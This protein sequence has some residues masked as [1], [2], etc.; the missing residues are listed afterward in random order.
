MKKLSGP[1]F[2]LLMA[3][4]IAMIVG[5]GF[6]PNFAARII[7]PEYRPPLILYLHAG[8]CAAWV[9]LLCVQSA[10][11]R[12]V[13]LRVHMQLG[14]LGFVLGVVLPILGIA[15]EIAMNRWH[16]SLGH[17]TSPVFVSISINDML[18]FATAFGFAMWWRRKP[19]FHKRL[20]LVATC[21]LTTAAFA[22]WPSYIVPTWWFYIFVDTLIVIGII[23]DLLVVRSVHPVYSIGLPALIVGQVLA[24][25]LCFQKPA[26]WVRF[27]NFL[28]G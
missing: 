4:L 15:T 8:V 12:S 17:T 26:F 7:Y 11:V 1:Y 25:Y 10:L 14:Q 23:R 9:L 5:V 16:L 13:H 19:E 28:L 6:G 3:L 24:F 20:L 18:S 21:C 2:Y 27:S 22:R